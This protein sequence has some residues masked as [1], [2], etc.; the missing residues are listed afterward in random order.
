[1]ETLAKAFVKSRQALYLDGTELTEIL[2]IGNEQSW[3]RFL[4]L[5][6]VKAYCAKAMLA[7]KD[8]QKRKLL[9]NLLTG[10]KGGN[11]QAAKAATDILQQYEAQHQQTIIL[12]YVPRPTNT[13]PTEPPQEVTA[14]D[15]EHMV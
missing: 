13:P 11:A 10:A 6:S 3:N 4:D 15:P 7:G 12:H 1:M 9:G 2:E 5:P 14:N 8:V